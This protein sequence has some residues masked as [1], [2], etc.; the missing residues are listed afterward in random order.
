MALPASVQKAADYADALEQQMR[1]TVQ[2]STPAGE[3]PNTASVT[4]PEGVGIETVQDESSE[5]D[6]LQ[7][8]YSSLRGKYDAEVPRLH[9]QNKELEAL[10]HKLQEE[11]TSLKSELA[12]AAQEKSYLT[13]QDTDNFGEEM[14]DLVRRGAR[15]ESAKFASEA[16]EMKSQLQQLQEQVKQ[17]KQSVAEQRER[18]FWET[19]ANEVPDWAQQNEDPGFVAWLKE[20]DPVYG[21]KRQEALDR[22]FN[23]LDA[24]S[25]ASIFKEYRSANRKRNPLER[26]V[27]PAHTKS[28]GQTAEQPR[29]WTQGEIEQFYNSVIHHEISEEEA[30]AIEKEIE[31]AVA[32]GRVRP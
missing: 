21:F 25:V 32:T 10:L 3:E 18:V 26:Q 16:A 30:K 5:L 14:V 19:L 4:E 22:V 9:S 23:A 11:N 17:Q 12:K 2:G 29:I 28:S 20:A 24:H 6:K 13:E 1:G 8:K 31:S 7:S 27:S 15:E